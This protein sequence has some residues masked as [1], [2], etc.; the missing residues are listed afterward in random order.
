MRHDSRCEIVS[1]RQVV[2][3]VSPILVSKARVHN[4]GTQ[5]CGLPQFQRWD[6]GLLGTLILNCNG[7]ANAV[8]FVDVL[9]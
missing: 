2:F 7:R 8:S 3:I 5:I 4:G 1:E 9:M 6:D